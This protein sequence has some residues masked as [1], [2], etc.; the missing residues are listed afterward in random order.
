MN[1][2]DWKHIFDTRIGILCGT[3]DPTPEQ[4]Q[5]ASDEADEYDA[6][7]LDGDTL[8]ALERIK[9]KARERRADHVG[10]HADKYRKPHND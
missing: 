2:A 6:N 8:A 5:I 9:V 3:D 1:S 4:M 7:Q 10:K